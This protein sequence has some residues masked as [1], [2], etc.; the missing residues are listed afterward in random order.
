MLGHVV[1]LRDKVEKLTSQ[2]EQLTEVVE[3]TRPGQRRRGLF[4]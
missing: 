3:T 2:V 1:D 4:G